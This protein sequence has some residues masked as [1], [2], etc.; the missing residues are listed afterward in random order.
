MFAIFVIRVNQMGVTD[1]RNL[2][3]LP[4]V[5]CIFLLDVE[6]EILPV[7]VELPGV[8][9]ALVV[10]LLQDDQRS[11]LTPVTA[12]FDSTV[13]PFQW[14]EVYQWIVAVEIGHVRSEVFLC[15]FFGD[16]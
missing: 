4:K 13:C 3:V 9:L 6:K 7:L 16:T 10:V 1:D 11:V 8:F 15:L 5:A 14:T 2:V 12:G